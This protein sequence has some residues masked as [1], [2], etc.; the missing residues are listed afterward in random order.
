VNHIVNNRFDLSIMIVNWN[1][2]EYLRKCLSSIFS[3]K[4]EF[5]LE[6]LVADNGSFDGCGEMLREDFP[7]V[8]FWQLP[9]NVGFAAANNFLFQL[10]RG[11]NL[12]FLNPDTEVVGHGLRRMLEVLAD[13]ADAGLAGP[14][15]VDSGLTSH[16]NCMRRF[17]TL[18]NQVLD[19]A[20]VRRI[21]LSPRRQSLGA[22]AGRASDP[23]AAEVVPGTCLMIKR[24]VFVEAGQFDEKYFMYAEDIDLCYSVRKLGWKIYY[25]PDAIVIHHGGQSSRQRAES[26]FSAVLMRDG[27]WKFL[28]GSRGHLYAT[29]Y[30]TA[31]SAAALCRLAIAAGLWLVSGRERRQAWRATIIKWASVWRWS[32]GLERWVNSLCAS[33]R[34]PTSKLIPAASHGQRVHA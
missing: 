1:S 20:V 30:R 3:I 26:A 17:P 19:A 29:A 7:Q 13:R 32:L 31:T 5:R 28:A 6:T 4:S 34:P 21:F 24:D 11:K 12:L 18:L 33:Q 9:T 22:G 23:V 27:V 8:R 10:S 14:C 15:L 25:I 2:A 16:R